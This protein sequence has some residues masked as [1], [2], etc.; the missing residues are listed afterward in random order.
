M[1]PPEI[2]LE[3]VRVAA[4]HRE[5]AIETVSDIEDDRVASSDLERRRDLGMPAV[6][7]RL[8]RLDERRPYIELDP[9]SRAHR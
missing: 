7:P 6:V 1:A 9:V 8:G 4:L 5:L 2:E 3:H